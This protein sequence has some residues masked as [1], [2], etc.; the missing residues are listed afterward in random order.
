[1]MSQ[2]MDNTRVGS[3]QQTRCSN[4]NLNEFQSSES[5]NQNQ[6]FSLSDVMN[7]F[8]FEDENLKNKELLNLEPIKNTNRLRLKN[9]QNNT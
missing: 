7:S 5:N 1:M 8:E 9:F 4:D 6:V 2:T 3:R